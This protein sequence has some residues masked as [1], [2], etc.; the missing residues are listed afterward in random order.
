M[1]GL[2]H[3]YHSDESIFIFRDFMCDF[4]FY[5]AMKFLL[6]NRIAP[7]VMLRSAASHVGLYCLPM[8]YK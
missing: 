1:N 3:H 2:A 6:A 4:K 7:D 5:F 8:S